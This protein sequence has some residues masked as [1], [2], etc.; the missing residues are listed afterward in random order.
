MSRNK[1]WY[2]INGVRSPVEV[3]RLLEANGFKTFKG[4]GP[5]KHGYWYQDPATK[6]ALRIIKADNVQMYATGDPLAFDAYNWDES[7]IV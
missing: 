3:R 2:V 7:D 1:P 6:L 5:K 4:N